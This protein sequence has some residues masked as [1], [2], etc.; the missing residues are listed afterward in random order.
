M[1]DPDKDTRLMCFIESI[2][3]LPVYL[4]NLL[5][6]FVHRWKVRMHS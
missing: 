3:L 1:C 2:I 5:A 6:A 4:A